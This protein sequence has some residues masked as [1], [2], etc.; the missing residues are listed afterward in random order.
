MSVVGP[1]DSKRR[2]LLPCDGFFAVI[3][4]LPWLVTWY[5]VSP[6]MSAMDLDGISAHCPRPWSAPKARNAAATDASIT[7]TPPIRRGLPFSA[8]GIFSSFSHARREFSRDMPLDIQGLPC[9]AASDGAVFLKR[10][11]G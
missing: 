1:G 7:A 11:G 9:T 3:E 5:L 6:S 2:H 8:Y 10:W 4:T